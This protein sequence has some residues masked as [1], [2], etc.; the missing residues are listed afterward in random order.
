MTHDIMWNV[1]GS[2]VHFGA[3]SQALDIQNELGRMSCRV[4][5]YVRDITQIAM[6]LREDRPIKFDGYVRLDNG[7]HKQPNCEI[8][9]LRLFTSTRNAVVCEADIVFASL[10]Q[11]AVPPEP[12]K[13]GGPLFHMVR[14]EAKL[15]TGLAFEVDNFEVHIKTE[16]LDGKY[17]YTG[18]FSIA[19]KNNI[20][21]VVNQKGMKLV[22]LLKNKIW[23]VELCLTGV[24]TEPPRSRLDLT[25]SEP[26][27]WTHDAIFTARGIGFTAQ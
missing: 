6:V 4:D 3:R 27:L 8:A 11:I 9:I 15:S 25:V 14:A 17:A 21:D 22:I 1:C 10:E 23:N 7:W 24:T 20:P 13:S 18:S 19:A 26:P 12:V 5:C 2:V 16:L